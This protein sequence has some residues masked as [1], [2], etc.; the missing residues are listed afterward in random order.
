MVTI[1]CY[2][3][4]QPRKHPKNFTK[5]LPG[6]KFKTY[7]DRLKATGLQSLEYRRLVADLIF[8]FKIVR[9]YSGIKFDDI[10]NFSKN[11]TSRGHSLRL[12]IPLSKTNLS[13]FSFAHRI[14]LPWNSLPTAT[15]M[16]SSVTSFKTKLL[17]HDLTKFLI[18]QSAAS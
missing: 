2:A 14:I 16:A 6:L 17:N 5:R 10:F 13:Q 11:T 1:Y 18:F 9:G 12:T 8:C 3:H 4:K 7:A 15:V